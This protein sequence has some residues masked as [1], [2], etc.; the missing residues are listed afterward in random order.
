MK[1][2]LVLFTLC[3]AWCSLRG[4]VL[5]GEPK[6]N[7]LRTLGSNNT[8]GDYT[9]SLGIVLDAQNQALAQARH[10]LEESGEGREKSAL[11]AAIKEMERSRAALENA[12]HTPDQLPTAMA[13]EEA[14]YQALLKTLP[15]E[16]RLSRARNRSQAAGGAGQPNQQELSQ[17][18]LNSEENRYE[19]ER[20]ASPTETQQQREQVQNLDRLKQLA[21]RQQDLNERLRDVQAALQE[22][23]SEPERRELQR[24]LKRLRDEQRQL[25]SAVDEMRQRMEQSPQASQQAQARQQLEQ[26]R[27]DMQKAAQD[28]ERQSASDAL[29]AGSR[30]EQNLQTLRETMRQQA[31]SRFGQQMRQLRNQAR[32]LANQEN[33]IASAL[34]S[35]NNSAQKQL[36][37]SAQ[38]E[39][40]ARQMERQQGALT[41]LLDGMR[42]VTE[43]AETTEPLL[44]KQLYDL[45]RRADQAHTDNQLEMGQ[46]LVERGFLPQ[47]SQTER[48]ARRNIDELRQGVEHA[49]QSVLGSESEALRYAQKQLE[50]LTAQVGNELAGNTNKS[51]APR[52]PA[53][54]ERSG[55]D[56]S[57]V[58][59]S[60]VGSEKREQ[61]G[62]ANPS[63]H[64]AQA[65]QNAESQPGN[66][67]ADF[68]PEQNSNRQ[69]SAGPQNN[70]TTPAASQSAGGAGRAVER[71]DQGV[72][73]AAGERER[74]RQFAEQLGGG[75]GGLGLNGPITGSSYLDWVDRMRDVEQAV[76]SQDVRNQL[77]TVRERVG[78]YRRDFRENRQRPAAGELQNKVLEPLALARAWVEQELSR[79]QN[80]RSLVPLDRDPVQDKYSDLVRRYYEEL[81]NRE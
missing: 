46:R 69:A 47:A 39:E 74:L 52:T 24:Q 30:A 61:P 26:T 6:T 45:L 2:F 63:S 51:G 59:K 43:Q 77:A 41:N 21:R 58:Q 49:A 37:D 38:R 33:Q 11:Q 12:K 73:G 54:T 4:P 79:V 7:P 76:D 75:R 14:A 34:E 10:A 53:A 65:S 62:R 48:I 9:S 15:R 67:K 70:G 71:P 55:T 13:A 28:L 22:A 64:Q 35:L 25:L 81:G 36:D 66:E 56:S 31:S 5:A 29:A 27:N 18:E 20:Q 19:T 1:P 32:N 50:E 44:S 72:P 78:V 60:N 42:G 16:Y 17:L 8:S 80:E 57:P 68:P 23:R 3:S 40:L